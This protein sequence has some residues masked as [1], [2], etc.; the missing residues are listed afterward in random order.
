MQ[1]GAAS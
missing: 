1:H